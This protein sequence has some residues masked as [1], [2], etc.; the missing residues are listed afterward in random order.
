MIRSSPISQNIANFHFIH[1]SSGFW[2]L[3]TKTLACIHTSLSL[4]MECWMAF[5][6]I[7]HDVVTVTIGAT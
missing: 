5:V 3:Q 2:V 1:S 4:M 7:S 6:F